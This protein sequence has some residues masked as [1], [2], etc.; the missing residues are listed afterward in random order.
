MILTVHEWEQTIFTVQEQ[1]WMILLYAH[2]QDLIIHD[3][4]WK[5]NII[6]D[7]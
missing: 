6:H 5:G 2:F 4:E 7:H 3:Q 1:E